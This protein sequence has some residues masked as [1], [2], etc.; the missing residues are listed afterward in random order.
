[1]SEGADFL[2]FCSKKCSLLSAETAILAL[3]LDKSNQRQFY[4]GEL[5]DL[6]SKL[7]KKG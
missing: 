1:M 7:R 2:S 5:Q 4:T 6:R 3:E